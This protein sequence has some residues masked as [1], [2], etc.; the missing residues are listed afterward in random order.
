MDTIREK[1]QP[2]LA[3]ARHIQEQLEAELMTLEES[4]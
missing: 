3:G 1:H 2:S 4:Q